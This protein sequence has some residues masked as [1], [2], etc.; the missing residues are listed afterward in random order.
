MEVRNCI[1]QFRATIEEALLVTKIGADLK[2]KGKL[3]TW[4]GSTPKQSEILRHLIKTYPLP[5]TRPATRSTKSPSM[6]KAKA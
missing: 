3:F 1:I 6:R 2:A 4:Y 5:A